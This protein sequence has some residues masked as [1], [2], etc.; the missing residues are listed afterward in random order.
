MHFGGVIRLPETPEMCSYREIS[1]TASRPACTTCMHSGEISSREEGERRIAHTQRR[2]KI[3]S[4]S[5]LKLNP[6]LTASAKL[7]AQP[8]ITG[9]SFTCSNRIALLQALKVC[10]I[11]F[12]PF[13]H[14][15]KFVQEQS[16]TTAGLAPSMLLST[17]VELLCRS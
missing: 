16:F 2:V 13:I 1:E 3:V 5:G 9:V 10:W 4:N 14:L 11:H 15:Y 12:L 17:I 6:L 7:R 8:W